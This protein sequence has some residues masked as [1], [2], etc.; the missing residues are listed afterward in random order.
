MQVVFIYLYIYWSHGLQ[1]SLERIGP[2]PIQVHGFVLTLFRNAP[3]MFTFVSCLNFIFHDINVFS[4]FNVQMYLL[5]FLTI[6]NTRS[7]GGLKK[8]VFPK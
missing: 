5:R 2:N 7:R 1:F 8:S 6:M 3:D 4:T